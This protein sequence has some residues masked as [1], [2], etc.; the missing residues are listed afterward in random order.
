MG[1]NAVNS[2]STVPV[3]TN[4]VV[5]VIYGTTLTGDYFGQAGSPTNGTVTPPTLVFEAADA[6]HNAGTVLYDQSLI[7][8]GSF[9]PT[10]GTLRNSDTGDNI[11]TTI[12]ISTQ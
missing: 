5:T 11:D 7:P 6:T 10:S 8:A 9:G 3:T 4:G 1:S 12:A 2:G